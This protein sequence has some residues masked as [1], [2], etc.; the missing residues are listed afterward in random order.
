MIK[1]TSRAILVTAAL[2]FVHGA[3]GA[4]DESEF[5]ILFV[6]EGVEETFYACSACH[7]E[8]IVAQQGL[9]REGWEELLE[10]MVEEQGMTELEPDEREKILSYLA[11]HYNTD[12]PNFPK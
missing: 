9:T 6:A 5:G 12:R 3:A 1:S 8:M 4:D 7:S 2:A 10:W 11:E